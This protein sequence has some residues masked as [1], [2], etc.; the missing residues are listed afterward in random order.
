MYVIMLS[1][2]EGYE[3]TYRAYSQ[4]CKNMHRRKGQITLKL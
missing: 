3:L 1:A 4:L 2:K